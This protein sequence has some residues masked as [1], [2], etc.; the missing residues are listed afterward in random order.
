MKTVFLERADLS[1][2]AFRAWFMNSKVVDESGEPAVVYHGTVGDFDVFRQTRDVG[3]H[4]GTKAAAAARLKHH[5]TDV[6]TKDRPQN[7]MPVYL[8]V[9]KPLELGDLLTWEPD[10][11]SRELVSRDIFSQGEYERVAMR[12]SR[13]DRNR[14]LVVLLKSKGYDGAS[15]KNAAEDI[16]STTWVA[17]D[18]WQVKSVFNRGTWDRRRASIME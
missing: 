18:P 13:D 4:F 6:M 16:G 1:D 8:S 5:A 15:Y 14:E 12:G 9:Q 7:V 2:P 3:F 11:I 17:F 10:D